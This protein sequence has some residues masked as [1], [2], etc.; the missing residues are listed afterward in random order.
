MGK[1]HSNHHR[2]CSCC[3]SK[4]KQ[5]VYPTKE[6]V[7]CNQSEE[8]VQHIHPT[9]TTIRNEHVI[10]NEHVYP[11]TTSVENIVEEVDVKGTNTGNCTV[12]G[13][14]RPSTW[15]DDGYSTCYPKK[16]KQIKQSKKKRNK[17]CCRRSWI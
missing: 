1:N 6:K 11:T 15:N 5:I 8:V 17:C 4:P 2:N 3:C 13:V 12:A 10:L 16:Q 14:A 7:I 9:H